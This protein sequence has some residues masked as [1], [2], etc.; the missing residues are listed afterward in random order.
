MDV[1]PNPGTGNFYLE[2]SSPISTRINVLVLDVIGQVVL[3]Q[4]EEAYSGQYRQALNLSGL[5]DG[6][7]MVQ[8]NLHDFAGVET[9]R[10]IK[11]I[12]LIK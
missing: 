8:V 7:Y 11:R 12:C 1:F 3:N 4:T 9:F 2:V 6:I 5:G 10:E